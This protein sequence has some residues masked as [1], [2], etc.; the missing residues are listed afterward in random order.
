MQ[1]VFTHLNLDGL[2]TTVEFLYFLRSKFDGGDVYLF[3]KAMLS[4]SGTTKKN[5]PHATDKTIRLWLYEVRDST[6]LN[7]VDI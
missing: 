2:S 1:I 4:K 7:G 5:V 3:P 6:K